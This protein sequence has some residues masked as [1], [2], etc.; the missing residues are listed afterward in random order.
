MGKIVYHATLSDEPPHEYGFP[1]HAGTIKSADHRLDSEIA[2]GVDW[3]PEN[4]GTKRIGVGSIHEYEISD[5]APTSRRTWED[6]VDGLKT[7]VPEHKENR[8]Y[9]Y[10]NAY[11]DRGNISYVIPS[12]FVGNHVKH[13]SRQQFLI[14]ADRTQ[15]AII[16]NATSTMVGG[17]PPFKAK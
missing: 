16:M 17:K 1:F 10:S 15:E 9:P 14:N 6:P 4:T 5:N 2:D 7:P 13:L 3:D 11:E 8:I 12:S